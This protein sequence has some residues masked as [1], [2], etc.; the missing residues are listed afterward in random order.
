MGQWVVK[1]RN[2]IKLTV[3]AKMIEVGVGVDDNYRLIR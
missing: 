3:T 1:H 2:F